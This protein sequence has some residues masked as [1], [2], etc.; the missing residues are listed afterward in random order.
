MSPQKVLECTENGIGIGEI[1]TFLEDRNRH[2]LPQPVLAFL[3]DMKQRTGQVKNVGPACLIE[4]ASEP[5]A[6]LI[7]NDT[8]LKGLC[9]LAGERHLVVPSEN[10]ML[11]KKALR[12]LG[13]G[14]KSNG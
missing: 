3:E 1:K 10:E 11:F 12:G 2:K 5:V 4:C 6:R 14:M 9:M 7:A 8:R 13:Y